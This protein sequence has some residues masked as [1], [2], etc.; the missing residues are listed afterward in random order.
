MS[1]LY[2]KKEVFEKVKKFLEQ[3]QYIFTVSISNNQFI[4][5]IKD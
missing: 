2:T 1:I 3:N 5:S 4:I